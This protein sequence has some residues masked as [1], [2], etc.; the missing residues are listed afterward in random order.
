[1]DAVFAGWLPTNVPTQL[2]VSIIICTRNRAEQLAV[3]LR[4]LRTLRSRPAEIVVVD[5]APTDSSTEKV[6]RN[7]PEAVYVREPRAGL[8]I[9]RNT[10]IVAAQ[11][12]IILFID[13]DVMVNDMLV[14][15]VWQAFE[16]P[17]VAAMTGLVIAHSLQTEAQVIFEKDWSFNRGYVDTYYTPDYLNQTGPPVWKIGAG[18]NMAFRKSIFE[19]AG[20][21]DELLDAGA[22]GCSGD[23]EMWHRIL[24]NGGTIHYNPRAVAHHAHREQLQDLKDQIFYYMRGHVVAALIQHRHRPQD[25][26]DRYLKRLY[27]YYSDLLGKHFPLFKYCHPTMWAEIKGAAAGVAYYYRHRDAA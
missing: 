7:F 12:E 1:M 26:Y 10:G 15:W 20:Y 6:V 25:G 18:A 21:F 13:D 9:A 19:Q 27:N 8:D 2:P 11:N 3:C 24:A 14:Y 5:N 23:S 17:A 16:E 22:A 4:Q